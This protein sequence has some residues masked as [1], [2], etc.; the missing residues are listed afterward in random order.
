MAEVNIRLV[1]LNFEPVSESP[2]GLVKNTDCFPPQ[3]L[4]LWGPWIC[5]SDRLPDDADDAG[6]R[7]LLSESLCLIN[8]VSTPERLK[9]LFFSSWSLQ[10]L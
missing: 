8:V 6:P 1:V 7:I 5:F 10:K 4:V 3:C 2:R 9:L